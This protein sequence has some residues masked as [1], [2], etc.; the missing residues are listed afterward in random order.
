[1]EENVFK[2]A[3]AAISNGEYSEN[4]VKAVKERLSALNKEESFIK[5]KMERDKNSFVKEKGKSNSKIKSLR[6]EIKEL[7]N[8]LNSVQ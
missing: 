4:D 1:M 8:F 3:L 7:K 6:K 5:R 2:A